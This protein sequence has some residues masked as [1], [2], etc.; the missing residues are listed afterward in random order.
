M[1]EPGARDWA[2]AIRALAPWA[3]RNRA[4]DFTFGTW[5][6]SERRADG[7]ASMPWFEVSPEGTA[8]LTAA[9]GFLLPAFEWPAWILTD[10][11]LRLRDDPEALASA[12]PRQVA[13]L[14][15]ALIRQDRFVE[16][17]LD[18][19]VTSGLLG[20]VLDRVAALADE[21]AQSAG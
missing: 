9:G 19:S 3:A 10:E 21:L 1:N 6:G 7:V 2:D 18:A 15:T 11:A 14:L 5:H 20:R 4:P 16:G 8:L 12:S 13:Q 17:A